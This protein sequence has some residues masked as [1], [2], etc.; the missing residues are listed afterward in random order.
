MCNLLPLSAPLVWLVSTYVVCERLSVMQRQA[1]LLEIF[2]QITQF[3]LN[4]NLVPEPPPP[5]GPKILKIRQI[6]AL[7]GFDFPEHPPRQCRLEYVETKCCIPQGYHLVSQ[8]HSTQAWCHGFKWTG[9]DGTSCQVLWSISFS[10]GILYDDLLLV[11]RKNIND[12]DRQLRWIKIENQKN[13]CFSKIFIRH[14]CPLWGDCFWTSGH[15]LTYWRPAWAA[16]TAFIQLLLQVLVYMR[17]LF[18]D[19]NLNHD[20][21]N[22]PVALPEVNHLSKREE[23]GINPIVFEKFSKTSLNFWST[24][25]GTWTQNVLLWGPANG[26]CLRFQGIKL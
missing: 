15:L 25:G 19:K 14:I 10:T 4:W 13:V 3:T 1:R 7:L 11:D 18:Y 24:L 6:L 12:K 8:L 2:D 16:G 9:V 26:Q 22:I 21:R 20:R 23:I 17:S 5:P